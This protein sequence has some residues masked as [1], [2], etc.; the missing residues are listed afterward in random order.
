MNIQK[1]IF[2]ENRYE[3]LEKIGSG[4]MSDVYKAHCHKL[5]RFV[6]IKF[7]KPEF[8]EDK[9]FVKNFQIEAQSAAALLHPNVVSVYDVNQTDGIY[10]IV[11]EYVDGITLKKYIDRNGRLPV[12]EATSIAIQIAQGID[13]AHNAHIIHRDIKPQN[14][15]ISREGKIKVTD[16]GIARTTT[17]NTISTD[18]LGSVQYI[19][20]E[21]ARGGQVDNRTD[22]YSFGIVYYEMVTGML[23]FDGDSTVSIALKHIQENVPMASDVV[24]GVPNSVSRIIEKCTQRKPDRRYQKMSSLLADLKTSLITPNEDF[25][26]LE[27]EPSESATI[28]MSEEDAEFLRREGEKVFGRSSRASS[29]GRSRQSVDRR[30]YN[31]RNRRPQSRSQY[32][33]YRRRDPD[34]RYDSRSRTRSKAAQKRRKLDK[35][36][37]ICGVVAGIVIIGLLAIVCFSTFGSSCAGSTPQAQ[38]ET[39]VP[40]TVVAA[41]VEVPGVL[42]MEVSQAQSSLENLGFSVKVKYAHSDSIARDYVIEQSV[43]SGV[44]LETG[45]EITLTVSSGKETVQLEN[46]TGQEKEQVIVKLESLGFRVKESEVY[47]ENIEAGLVVETNPVAGSE[48]PKDAEIELKVSQGPEIIYSYVPDVRGYSETNAI[49]LLYMNSLNA[50]VS[51]E[52]AEG[53]GGLVFYQDPAPGTE[54]EQWSGVSIVVGVEPYYEYEEPVYEEYEEPQTEEPE[55]TIQEEI[56]LDET[57]SEEI[58][59]EETDPEV[60]IQEDAVITDTITEEADTEIEE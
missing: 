53:M 48:V 19:S 38:S 50:W 45:Q 5:N 42:G 35:V 8:C 51:Y 31:D 59:P 34:P 29:S 43:K 22:I 15:L 52:E 3:I 13:A 23:P 6:A 39:Q 14:V 37:V 54:L 2:I 26:V 12:K 32:Q 21:Q 40:T 20:P 47:D 9:N 7:L 1:G 36:L 60:P 11:M 41:G 44:N 56:I 10:Y 30:P 46:Y 33:D 16:F 18:I 28:I 17:A 25:V 49:D 4:G 24:D 27:P 58:V 57:P 55:T